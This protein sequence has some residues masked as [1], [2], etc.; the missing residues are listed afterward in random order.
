MS[1]GVGD[2]A[3]HAT[4]IAVHLE[5]ILIMLLGH[6]FKKDRGLVGPGKSDIRYMD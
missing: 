3:D 4:T 1:L 6:S 2:I 5:T